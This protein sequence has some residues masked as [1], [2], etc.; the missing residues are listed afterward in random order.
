MQK[1]EIAVNTLTQ[2]PSNPYWGTKTKHSSTA[3]RASNRAASEM[4]ILSTSVACAIPL[5]ETLSPSSRRSRKPIRRRTASAKK[6]VSV[7][8]PRPP[9]WIRSRMT[10]CPNP[11]NCVQVSRTIRPV[12]QVALVAVNMASITPSCPLRLE[13]GRL[14]SRVPAAISSRKLPQISW[15]ALLPANHPPRCLRRAKC[16]VFSFIGMGKA[17][18]LP[19]GNA[20]SRHLCLDF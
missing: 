3:P 10:A 6:L 16:F 11:V 4:T 20:V 13:I 2:M 1:A 15:V 18:F 19:R 5:A 7:T 9:I 8:N 14:S 12:T 17:S